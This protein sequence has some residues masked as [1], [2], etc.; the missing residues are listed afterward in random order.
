M[1]MLSTLMRL[2]SSDQGATAVEYG[3]IVSLI[4]LSAAGAIGVFGNGVNGMWNTISS[5]ALGVL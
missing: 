1:T 2:R 3:L 5:S 4:F